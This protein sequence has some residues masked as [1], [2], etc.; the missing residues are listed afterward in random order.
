MKTLTPNKISIGPDLWNVGSAKIILWR[1]VNTEDGTEW[2]GK[3][4]V[5]L[6][7]TYADTGKEHYEE[8][9]GWNWIFTILLVWAGVVPKHKMWILA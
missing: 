5:I 2:C 6:L 7:M 4:L 9:C 1:L 8:K 3:L